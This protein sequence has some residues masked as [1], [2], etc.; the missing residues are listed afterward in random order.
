[1]VE[2]NEDGSERGPA[3]R[4]G[5]VV[6]H[7]AKPRRRQHEVLQQGVG[8]N[9]EVTFRSDSGKGVRDLQWDMRPNAEHVLDC[10]HIAMRVTVMQQIAR[11][12]PPPHEPSALAII[13]R[14]ERVRRFLWHCNGRRSLELISDVE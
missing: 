4:F 2:A 13:G 8:M 6:G 1:M 3:R 9:R 12:L 14:L 5:F 10:F 7:D 11:G